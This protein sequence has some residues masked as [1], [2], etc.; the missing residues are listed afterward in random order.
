MGPWALRLVL[1]L[2]EPVC[3]RADKSLC[4]SGGRRKKG[5]NC[6]PG[7]R[8]Y[9][10]RG[11]CGILALSLNEIVARKCWRCSMNGS[12]NGK[13]RHQKKVLRMVFL[14]AG[15]GANLSHL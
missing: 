2:L 9:L 8:V 4:V 3:D 12:Q 15:S 1:S 13:N 5:K 7:K 11:T 6:P 10:H 14:R